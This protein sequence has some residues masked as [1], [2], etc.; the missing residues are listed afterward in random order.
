[1]VLMIAALV[2]LW[3]CAGA[4]QKQV[5]FLS[6][7]SHL[8]PFDD[9][10]R[11]INFKKLGNYSK[12]IFDPVAVHFHEEAKGKKTDEETLKQLKNY[13]HSAIIKA[14]E[15]LPRSYAVVSKPGPGV[16]RVRVAMTDVD[17]SSPVLNIIPQTKLTGVGL[18]GM[19]ME[20]EVVD[21]QTNEQIGAVIQTQKGKRLSLAGI[22][23]W[24]DAKAVMDDW[25]DRFRKRLDEAHGR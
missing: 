2:M 1:M 9:G 25:A 19:S 11:Y 21:S 6:D 13:M 12:F 15:A 5:G 7:Y 4:P 8:E 23:K 16:A 18:G 3:G 24:G 20:G 22:T 17:K 14:I 10:L